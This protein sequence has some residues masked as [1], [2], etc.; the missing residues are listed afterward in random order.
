[1][2]N[3]LLRLLLAAIAVPL[4]L[5]FIFKI[6]QFNHIGMAFFFIFGSMVGSFELAR[7]FRHKDINVS[8][9]LSII[10]GF[11]IPTVFWLAGN[12]DM[13]AW[14]NLPASSRW[15]A[16]T[17]LGLICLISE[18]I[19]TNQTQ[20]D[21]ALLT[22]S[23]HLMVL[24][25]P[26]FLTTYIIALGSLDYS[27]HIFLTFFLLVFIN[28]SMAYFSGILFGKKSWKPFP[29]SPNKS[30]VG[31]IGGFISTVAAA[32]LSYGLK[33]VVYENNFRYAIYLG[34]II[35][36][37]ANAGDL[38]ESSIKRSAGVKDSG[39]MMLGRGG[40]L[41]SMDSLLFSAPALY[42]FFKYIIQ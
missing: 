10:I 26:A 38:V 22:L 27:S 24:F 7:M 2:K 6:T 4:I 13:P 31:Y 11:I 35:S 41:D 40:V 34:I 33:P 36:L 3:I 5:L 25:Y 20:W 19:N 32:G 16:L 17:V 1:M 18:I 8:Y 15:I 14:L 37:A 30:I 28:D 21:N 23:A 12:E 9:S 29:V 42:L 39:K